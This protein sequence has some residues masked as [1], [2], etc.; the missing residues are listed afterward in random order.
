MVLSVRG[1]LEGPDRSVSALFIPG[2]AP[3]RKVLASARKCAITAGTPAAAKEVCM[4]TQSYDR[5]EGV[6]WYDGKLV[7]WSEANSMC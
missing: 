5:L 4:A 7:P 6:I 2:I 1:V 3:R